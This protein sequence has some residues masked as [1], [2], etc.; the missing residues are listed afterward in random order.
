[1]DLAPGE[2]Y[3]SSTTDFEAMY[4]GEY[5][6]LVAVAAAL[7][8]F[9]RDAEDL[10]Q[11]AMVRAF[12]HWP[13]VSRYERPGA[14]CHRVVVNLCRNWWRR[15]L[16]QRRLW[17]DEPRVVPG[18]SPD[19]VAFWQAVRRLPERQRTVVALYY[20]ADRPAAEVAS[21]LAVPEGTVRSD[22]ARARALLAAE[23]EG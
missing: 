21:I 11:D 9:R 20:A 3:V 13:K 22:L 23:L 4:R 12:L 5:P 16:R 10:V 17:R 18:V 1:M 19:V 6:G 2:P 8:E 15:H 7:V 14:W